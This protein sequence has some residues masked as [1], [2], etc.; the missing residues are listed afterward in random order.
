MP[1]ISKKAVLRFG[2][3]AGLDFKLSR[4]FGVGVD[5]NF[6]KANRITGFY[7][8]MGGVFFRF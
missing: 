2:H 5:A 8:V 4:H 3:R 7:H 6:V 1:R